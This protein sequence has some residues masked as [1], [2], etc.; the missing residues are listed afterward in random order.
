M[1]NVVEIIAGTFDLTMDRRWSEETSNSLIER[2]IAPYTER[3]LKHIENFMRF[4]GGMK[5]I[6][7]HAAVNTM[8]AHW[9]N[10]WMEG[11]DLVSIYG[12]I[13]QRKPALYLEI[14]S[15]NS[16]MFARQSVKDNSPHTRIIS[17]DPQPRAN[18]DTLCDQVIRKRLEQTDWQPLVA[19][20]KPGD[21]L[22]FDGSHRCL[23]NSDVT[24]FFNEILPHVPA[25]VMIGIHDIFLPADYPYEWIPR[26][27]SEQYM[28]ATWLLAD[29]GRSIDIELPVYWIS[30]LP[31]ADA[32]RARIAPL[33]S[34]MPESVTCAGGAFW[35]SK[36][37]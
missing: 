7:L 5:N 9:H 16:T 12:F 33:W 36:K 14:G 8:Q 29:K 26:F 10:G 37:D 4:A 21:I 30:N 24:V 18:I 27:Y 34:A 11:L 23:Q 25:G 35:F 32:L 19:A 13:A 31:Q 2:L 3:Y 1:S 15:G 20:L 17:I 28:L 22:F 6:P